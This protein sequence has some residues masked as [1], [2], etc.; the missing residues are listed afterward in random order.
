MS[1]FTVAIQNR[2]NF[3]K[4]LETRIAQVASALPQ[5][6]DRDFPRQPAALLKKNVKVVITRSG[7]TSAEPKRKYMRAAPNKPDKKQD[8]AEAE[9]VAKPRP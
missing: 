6:N 2:L 8:E 9:I 7:K 5:P 1:N 4:M 3:N